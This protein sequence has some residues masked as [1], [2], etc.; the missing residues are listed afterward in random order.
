M[1]SN[2]GENKRI[3]KKGKNTEKSL[4]I[5]VSTEDKD[6]IGNNNKK[7]LKKNQSATLKNVDQIIE[8]DIDVFEKTK[9]LEQELDNLKIEMNNTSQRAFRELEELNNKISELHQNEINL[10][11]K[12]NN[13]MSRLK[14]IEQQVSEKFSSKFKISKILAK[15][16]ELEKKKDIN[17]QIKSAEKQQKTAQ[18][19]I[20]YYEK[21]IQKLEALLEENKDGKEEE[22]NTKL[23]DFNKSINENLNRIKELNKMK[24]NHQ[25]CDN[26]ITN[27]N[28]KL[29]ELKNEIEF[30][31]KLLNMK[32]SKDKKEADNIVQRESSPNEPIIIK[33]KVDVNSNYGKKVI[34]SEKIRDKSLKKANNKYSSKQMI[35]RYKYYNYLTN[36]LDDKSMIDNKINIKN[37]NSLDNNIN[38]T[39]RNQV[40]TMA[41]AEQNS[42][43]AYMKKE[44]PAKI[45]ITKPKNYLISEKENKYISKLLPEDY[46]KKV[47][48]KYGEIENKI[49]E[50]EDG[51]KKENKQ[52]K[53]SLDD[54]KIQIERLNLKNKEEEMKKIKNNDIFTKNKK[55]ILD[56]KK[57]ISELNENINK[58]KAMIK[59]KDKNIE[60]LSKK[61]EELKNMKNKK[62]NEEDEENEEEEGANEEKIE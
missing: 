1:S 50:I 8:E 45:K 5:K 42:F 49:K 46:V 27:L 30:Q 13:L 9:N 3:V 60:Y 12:K 10:V 58:E 35:N 14:G 59:K 40:K 62:E 16:K 7:T 18:K 33:N 4:N 52:L 57:Q 39:N 38:Q 47:T 25:F 36:E 11:S 34:F 56:L 15:K 6:Q 48:E 61:I 24:K 43:S 29:N 20:K 41:N 28:I 37:R 2:A 22:L 26:A 21:E 54:D 53:S 19:N 17:T 44:V 23:T 55:K 31:K 51:K 32:E